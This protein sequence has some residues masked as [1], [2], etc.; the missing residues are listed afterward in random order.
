MI[1]LLYYRTMEPAMGITSDEHGADVSVPIIGATLD[2]VTDQLRDRYA[3][4]DIQIE[5][6]TVTRIRDG[7]ILV[8]KEGD[9]AA[10]VYYAQEGE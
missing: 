5:W 4:D 9:D 3:F 7:W 10:S 6:T 8:V 2:D 1:R